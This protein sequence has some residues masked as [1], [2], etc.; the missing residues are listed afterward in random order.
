[1]S[2][3]SAQPLGA[4]TVSHHGSC[5]GQC[6]DIRPRGGVLWIELGIARHGRLGRP[7]GR[8]GLLLVGEAGLLPLLERDPHVLGLLDGIGITFPI[9]PI[10]IPEALADLLHDSVVIDD[11]PRSREA[12]DLLAV[13]VPL[14]EASW[15]VQLP[16]VLDDVLRHGP[17][18]GRRVR[19]AIVLVIMSGDQG[20]I[21]LVP[22]MLGND[23]PTA[24][25]DIV[26]VHHYRGARG[27]LLRHGH[28]VVGIRVTHRRNFCE[29][30]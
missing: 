4:G 15:R 8:R 21:S 26:I 14:E 13:A 20:P 27:L 22:G 12:P 6:I 18:L 9:L 17:L 10:A 30:S 16:D 19:F 28:V 1:M 11:L 3:I 23:H 2:T 7:S 24:A 29:R 5:C 25:E